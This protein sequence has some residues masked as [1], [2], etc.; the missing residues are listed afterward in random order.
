[1]FRRRLI[2]LLKD[3]ASLDGVGEVVKPSASRRIVRGAMIGGLAGGLLG[4]AIEMTPDEYGIKQKVHNAISEGR[5]LFE[6]NSI[7]D[8]PLVV[9]KPRA[10]APV[11]EVK[12][13]ED[14]PPVPSR[15]LPQ[16]TPNTVP[17]VSVNVVEPSG[18]TLTTDERP[19]P[20]ESL[21][22]VSPV[23]EEDTP[24]EVPTLVESSPDVSG[25]EPSIEPE[26]L[27]EPISDSPESPPAPSDEP[28]RDIFF[29][30]IESLESE[31]SRLKSELE[32][33]KS[34]H[35]ESMARAAGAAKASLE[36]IDRMYNEREVAM[37]VARQSILVTDL[38]DQLARDEMNLSPGS[39][40]IDFHN[41]KGVILESCFQ[42]EEMN[43][44]IVALSKFFSALYSVSAGKRIL[45]LGDSDLTTS[46]TWRNIRA[47]HLA[48]I[49]IEK[50]DFLDAMNHLQ[51]IGN[52]SNE[53]AQW[54]DKTRQALE[55]WQGSRAAIAS[56]HDELSRVL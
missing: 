38:L 12:K 1:M 46:P 23:S 25:N 5:K 49:A 47:I 40:K 6:A 4:L 26:Q 33:E 18:Q 35:E 19:L 21:E 11:K 50:N 34:N 28:P 14:N 56:M 8:K 43:L 37:S 36:T 44:V 7:P 15:P 39:L 51:G 30:T 20:E 24:I 9:G 17:E 31:I 22:E 48:E 10:V 45:T 3:N 53:A 52:F 41:K 55:L 27:V 54:V 42:P 13:E 16:T 32:L 2:A 29:S